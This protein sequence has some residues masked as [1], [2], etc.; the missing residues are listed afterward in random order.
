MRAPPHAAR[1]PRRL[2]E[3]RRPADVVLQQPV[4]L[5]VERRIV[6]RREVGALEL[7]DRRDQRLGHE[8]PAELAEV[9]ARVR[10]AAERRVSH[11]NC[12]EQA[13]ECAP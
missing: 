10:I 2:V 5:R 8:A 9:A 1:Q 3:R 7:L 13:R 4:E 6:A 11:C 12:L